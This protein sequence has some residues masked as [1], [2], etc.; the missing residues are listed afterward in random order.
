MK[1]QTI[2]V[3]LSTNNFNRMLLKVRDESLPDTLTGW[4]TD[5]A[6]ALS[7]G[8]SEHLSTHLETETH[9]LKTSLSTGI[10]SILAVTIFITR[11]LVLENY[12]LYL[13]VVLV[14]TIVIFALLYYYISVAKDAPFQKRSLEMPAL[15]PG[16]ALFSFNHGYFIR[17]EQ[18]VVI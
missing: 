7:M 18:G 5:I 16:V 15:S 11:Y 13:T 3:T 1:T 2:E 9:P 6:A 17:T 10:A 8:A 4:I 12:C 14:T